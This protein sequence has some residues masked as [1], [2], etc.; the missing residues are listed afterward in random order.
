MIRNVQTRPND[1]ASYNLNGTQVHSKGLA[2]CKIQMGCWYAR[3]KVIV[4]FNDVDYCIIGFDIL[5]ECPS[6]Q[7]GLQ[8]ST[9]NDTIQ[10]NNEVSNSYLN[11]FVDNSN[12]T[13]NDVIRDII[14]SNNVI[15]VK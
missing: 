11:G 15:F 5:R 14:C 13:N 6:T 10:V 2:F 3:D 9:E 1:Q 8:E 12:R 4:A 7:F